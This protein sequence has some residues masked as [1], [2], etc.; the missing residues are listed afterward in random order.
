MTPTTCHEKVSIQTQIILLLMSALTIMSNVAIV[1]TLPHFNEHFAVKNIEFYSR[2][3]LTIS[4]LSVAFLAP[5]VGSFVYFF[6]KKNSAILGLFLFALFGSS[7]LYLNSIY[8]LLVSRFLFGIS[9][10]MLMI[11]STSLVGDYFENN[12]RYKFLS[13]QNLFVALGGISFVIIGGFLTDIFWRLPFGIYFLG[14]ILIPGVFLHIHEK[15]QTSIQKTMPLN[16]QLYVVYFFTFIYMAIFFILPTQMPFLMI[17]QFGASGK[18]TGAIISTSF[19]GT[20]IGAFVYH[21]IKSKFSFYEIYL[22]ANLILSF[23]LIL[24]GLVNHIYLFFCTAFIMGFGAGNIMTNATAWVLFLAKPTNRVKATAFLSSFLF[25]GQFFSPFLTHPF[26]QKAGIQGAF[27]ML[28]AI[29]FCVV[30]FAI[31]IKKAKK[32]FTF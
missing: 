18:L 8:L 11:V 26:I 30:V 22:Y 23:G 25:L 19:I 2:L 16:K 28:G 7:G 32:I 10:A 24:I 12:Q 31:I 13:K 20:G 27:I 29:L 4:S 15:K 1:T 6:G 5:L 9:I 14:L 17:S 21:K 3:M